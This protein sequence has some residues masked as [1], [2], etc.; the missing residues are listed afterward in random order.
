MLTVIFSS[1]L[2]QHLHA[3]QLAMTLGGVQGVNHQSHVDHHSNPPT[4][5]KRKRKSEQV[6]LFKH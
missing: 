6:E 5:T 4:L 2:G 3:Q 1:N